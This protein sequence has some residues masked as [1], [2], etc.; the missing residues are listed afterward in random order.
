ME[1]GGGRERKTVSNIVMTHDMQTHLM[2]LEMENN[3]KHKIC[4]DKNN[5]GK[6]AEESGKKRRNV[7]NI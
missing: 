4:V 1:R 3:A 7:T 6:S 2:K 5:K